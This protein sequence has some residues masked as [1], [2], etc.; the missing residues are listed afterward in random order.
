MFM[1]QLKLKVKNYS[2]IFLILK[3]TLVL[4]VF[5]Q[6]CGQP[7]SEDD[8]LGE[9]EQQSLEHEEKDFA[10]DATI[11]HIA[12]FSCSGTNLNGIP[13]IK[14]AALAGASGVKLSDDW[15]SKGTYNSDRKFSQMV[16]QDSLNN[17][18]ILQL[19]FRDNDNPLKFDSRMSGSQHYSYA[20]GGR[21]SHYNILTELKNAPKSSRIRFLKNKAGLFNRNLE[22]DLNLAKSEGQHIGL[23]TSLANQSSLVLGYATGSENPASLIGSGSTDKPKIYGRK[24]SLTFNT[25]LRTLSTINE[26][27]LFTDK[28]G[29][30]WKCDAFSSY[31]VVRPQD[32]A[33]ICSNARDLSSAFNDL[34]QNEKL[35]LMILRRLLDPTGNNWMIDVKLKCLIP[36]SPSMVCYGDAP[37]G[38]EKIDYKDSDGSCKSEDG[39]NT[40]TCPHKLSICTKS[41]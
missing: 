21:L 40:R 32:N 34:T 18:A 10:F 9:S 31:T 4:L 2:K 38:T 22:F 35:E 6:N 8:E 39:T 25:Q 23:R 41:Q 17:N 30:S 20:F 16:A 37:Q 14:A 15:Y 7:L 5:F 26:V 13:T 24:Y 3:S 27:N 12:Y 1:S 11:D 29:G 36:K 28:P 33:S 19:G